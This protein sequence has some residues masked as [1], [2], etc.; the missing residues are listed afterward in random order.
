MKIVKGTKNIKFNLYRKNDRLSDSEYEVYV[1]AKG[2]I[3]TRRKKSGKW[4]PLKKRKLYPTD[5]YFTIHIKNE[6]DIVSRLV[7]ECW[8]KLPED[9]YEGDYEVHHKNKNGFDNRIENL[10]VVGK[11]LHRTLHSL[12]QV[13]LFC[14]EKKIKVPLDDIYSIFTEEERDSI[15]QDIQKMHAGDNDFERAIACDY[16][17]KHIYVI[18]NK[19]V[20]EIVTWLSRVTFWYRHSVPKKVKNPL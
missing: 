1:S 4:T 9:F 13:K 17:N 10:I 20:Y 8:G 19:K 14:T 12:K 7:M 3:M 18:K 15:L 16:G 2:D 11:K 5:K 6:S